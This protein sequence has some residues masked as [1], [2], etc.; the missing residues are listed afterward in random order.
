MASRGER[1][2]SCKRN[3]GFWGLVSSILSDEA[4]NQQGILWNLYDKPIEPM[5]RHL[6]M[7]LRRERIISEVWVL[8]CRC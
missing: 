4:E 7:K 5:F 1:E 2:R 3:R 8:Y 6:H